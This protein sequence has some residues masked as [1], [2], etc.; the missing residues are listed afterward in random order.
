MFAVFGLVS[1]FFP[2]FL[3]LSLSLFI[4]AAEIIIIIMNTN[5]FVF[6]YSFGLFRKLSAGRCYKVL[7]V[8][9]KLKNIKLTP[10]MY[11]LLLEQQQEQTLDLENTLNC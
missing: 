2:L 10:I 7:F 8:C 6:F 4:S 1:Y 5:S 11:F 9:V 3:N